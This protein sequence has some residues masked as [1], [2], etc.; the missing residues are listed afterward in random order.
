[1]AGAGL[2]TLI[3]IGILGLVLSAAKRGLPDQ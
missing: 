2:I 3:I 1:M